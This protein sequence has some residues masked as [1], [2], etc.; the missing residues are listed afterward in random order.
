VTSSLLIPCS[1]SLAS[2]SYS[3]SLTSNSTFDLNSLIR[4]NI[5]GA[6]SYSVTHLLAVSWANISFYGGDPSATPYP[7]SV[8]FYVLRQTSLINTNM[9]LYFISK[10][11]QLLYPNTDIN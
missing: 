8:Y 2:V 7:V 11:L 9:L 6:S 5:P 10:K 1:D 3:L 4:A